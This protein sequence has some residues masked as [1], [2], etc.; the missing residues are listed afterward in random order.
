MRERERQR[1]RE[2][3]R[4][5]SKKKKKIYTHRQ[6]EVRLNYIIIITKKNG[7]FEMKRRRCKLKS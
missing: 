1:E 4:E 5:E 3:D 2:R 7:T 6:H